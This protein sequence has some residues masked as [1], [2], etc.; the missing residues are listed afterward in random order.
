MAGK[1][2]NLA[3]RHCYHHDVSLASNRYI[4][5]SPSYWFTIAV[6]LLFTNTPRTMLPPWLHI[7]P[8]R[9]PSLRP[10]IGLQD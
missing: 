1:C 7:T 3:E 6:W 5:L 2:G 9:V 4:F 10:Q 8:P